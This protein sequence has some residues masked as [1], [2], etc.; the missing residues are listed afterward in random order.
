MRAVVYDAFQATPRV[1][2]VPTPEPSATGAL[3]RVHATGLC[4]SD[5]HGW[6]GHDPD[7]TSFPHVPGH[8]L[9]GT[10]EAVGPEVTRWQPGARVTVPFVCACGECTP[11]RR[12]D[13]QVCDAQ[14]QP[15]FTHWG[16]YAE[17]AVI[18]HADINLV[19]L[20]DALS[21]DTAAGLGCRFATAFRAIVEQGRVAEGQWVA[22]FGCGGVGLSAIMIAR[23]FGARPIAVDVSAD[24][25]ALA[26]AVGAEAALDARLFGDVATSIHELTGG[27]ADLA[28]DALGSTST[29]R[30]AMRSLRKNGRQVQVGLLA[31]ADAEPSL[32]LHLLIAGELELVG[33]H[34]M[35]AHAYPRMLDMVTSGALDPARLITRR[36]SLDEAPQALATMVSATRAGVTIINPS[37]ALR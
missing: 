31:G 13:G 25:L 29:A 35:A 21:F 9:A 17:Y 23:A 2:S 8:E 27:G 1:A 34:G 7:I 11:C 12:G 5:W 19:A 24:A 10:V 6:Q 14:T 30:G 16:S 36:I 3:I 4:R 37:P 26:Q 15:G 32:P 22:V 20:P 33:S 18:H 28:C